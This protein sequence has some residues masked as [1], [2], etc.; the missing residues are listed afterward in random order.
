MFSSERN[1]TFQQRSVQGEG[2][3]LWTYTH[4]MT[5]GRSRFRTMSFFFFNLR[6]KLHGNTVCLRCLSMDTTS[7]KKIKFHPATLSRIPDS[8]F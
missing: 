7:P 2:C 4:L 1:V 8:K 3:V 6:S 5:Q